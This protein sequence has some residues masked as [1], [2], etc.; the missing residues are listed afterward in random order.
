MN[1]FTKQR[2]WLLLAVFL[3]ITN[4]ATVTT[5]CWHNKHRGKHFGG[6][7][8]NCKPNDFLAEKLDLDDEQQKKFKFIDSLSDLKR[9]GLST[10][11]NFQKASLFNYLKADTVNE[12]V[13][14]SIVKKIGTLSAEYNMIKIENI[15]RLRAI[16]T[17]DQKEE[18][19]EM[20]IRMD[21]K[22]GEKEGRGY[23]EERREERGEKEDGGDK[24]EGR[25]K[26]CGH[27]SSCNGD[28]ERGEG[29]HDRDGED[30]GR[31]ERHKKCDRGEKDD[32]ERDGDGERERKEE[33]ED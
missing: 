7:E 22:R 4:V 29:R 6:R 17:D 20:L 2:I 24:C 16:C 18:L 31:G 27:E 26:G 15:L 30:E 10:Q 28:R 1:F 12:K 21:S 5:M 13:L 3:L 33:K 32:H 11:I 14:D 8:A 9:N 23:N 19:T 25:G